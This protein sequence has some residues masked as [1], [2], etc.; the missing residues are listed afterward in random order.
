M[1]TGGGLHEAPRSAGSEAAEHHK[2]PATA[3]ERMP[4]DADCREGILLAARARRSAQDEKGS[5]S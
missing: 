1:M 2:A 5:V 3:A 4:S